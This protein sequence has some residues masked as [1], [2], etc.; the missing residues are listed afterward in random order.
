MGMLVQTSNY[1]GSVNRQWSLDV[2]VSDSNGTAPTLWY[3]LLYWADD[4]YGV[5]NMRLRTDG[6]LIVGSKELTEQPPFDMVI[7]WGKAVAAAD[8]RLTAADC[9][10]NA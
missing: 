8:W 5:W 4:S 10:G 1:V 3:R 9:G 7:E 6:G 2:C